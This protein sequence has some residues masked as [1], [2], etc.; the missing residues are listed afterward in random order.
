MCL[1]SLT[2]RLTA[3]VTLYRINDALSKPKAT[4]KRLSSLVR[5]MGYRNDTLQLVRAVLPDNEASQCIG[6][7]IKGSTLV[8]M[9]ESA[10]W[11]TR[12]RFQQKTLLDE[13]SCLE[14]FRNVNQLRCVHIHVS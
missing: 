9:A 13:L 4:H 14:R 6:A 5:Q 3:P 10:A 12:L 11:A 7:E 2:S 8:L 1:A